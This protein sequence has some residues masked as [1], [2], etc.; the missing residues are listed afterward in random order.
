MTTQKLTKCSFCKYFSG[1][2]CMTKPD[3]FYCKEAIN[4]YL[5]YIKSQNTSINKKGKLEG[6]ALLDSLLK[7][8]VTQEFLNRFKPLFKTVVEPEELLLYE[9]Y[10]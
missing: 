6:Y 4:E 5:Q 1:T 2:V 9:D 8:D 10:Q 7:R 3:S